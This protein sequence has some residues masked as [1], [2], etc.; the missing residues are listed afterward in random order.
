MVMRIDKDYCFKRNEKI[1]CKDI[2][3]ARALIDPYRRTLMELNPVALRIW[4]LLDGQRHTAA[5]IETLK[6]EYDADAGNIEKDV[7]AFLAG[8]L[9]REMIQKCS[10]M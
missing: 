4:Q 9:R 2:G 7:M 8:L 5:I 1:V 3:G 10:V 6:D